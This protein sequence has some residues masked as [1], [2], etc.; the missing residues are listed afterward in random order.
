MNNSKALVL[1]KDGYRCTVLC[2]NGSFRNV[3][4]FQH[5]D[6]GEEI[7]IRNGIESFGGARAWIGAAVIFFIVFSTLIGWNLY[8]A[9]TAAAVLSVDINPSI[10][11]SVDDQGNLLSI[12]T[13]NKDAEQLL[14]QADLKGKPIDKVLEQFVTEAAQQKLLDP[15]LPWIVVGYSS[16]ENDKAEQGN[17]NLKESQIISCLTEN[18][19]KNGFKPQVAFFTLTSQERELAQKGHLTL[20]EYALWQ[21]AVKAGVITQ[22]EKLSNTEERIRLLEDPK[23]QAQVKED[24][25]EHKASASLP[26]PEHGKSVP[27]KSSIEKDNVKKEQD[28]EKDNNKE[29]INNEKKQSSHSFKDHDQ[30]RGNNQKDQPQKIQN[31]MDKKQEKDRENNRES[32]EH[33]RNLDRFGTDLGYKLK[34]QNLR[35]SFNNDKNN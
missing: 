8:Q 23:V 22:E 26:Q 24:N 16:L 9:P 11:F 6:V 14:N 28:K 3:Y 5:T 29:K 7:I 2:E 4:R 35:D 32:Q 19:Q 15:K 12:D 33:Q 31:P 20:G 1:E 27:E 34:W 10:Q 30:S 13:K 18:A 17:G 25:N 21:T